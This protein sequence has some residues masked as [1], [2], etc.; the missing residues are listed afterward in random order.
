MT[1]KQGLRNGFVHAHKE[2]AW[3]N[4]N[5]V[6]YYPVGLSRE[7]GGKLFS[8]VQRQNER[9]QA[10]ITRSEIP[11]R[12]WEICFHSDGSQTWSV[13]TVLG[14]AQIWAG[15]SP[16]HPDLVGPALSKVLDWV[17]S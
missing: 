17:T 12:Y 16:E 11:S 6:S 2:E 14:D 15:H 3:G 8:Q 1:H 5:G 9:Q 13:D 10:L 4:L 7:D